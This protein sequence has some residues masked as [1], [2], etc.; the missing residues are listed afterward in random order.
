LNLKI[1]I[2]L[3]FFQQITFAE[4]IFC[5]KFNLGCST[6]KEKQKALEICRDR[7]NAVYQEWLIKSLA[8]P[9]IWQ[10]AGSNN[11]QAYASERSRVYMDICIKT[12]PELSN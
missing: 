10:L 9:S 2:F 6:E 8:D 1:L 12:S 5:R 7:S 3:L 11:A 4:S